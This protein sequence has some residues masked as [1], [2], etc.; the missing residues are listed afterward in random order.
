MAWVRAS[1]AE[2]LRRRS[3]SVWQKLL[4][5][6]TASS[7]SLASSASKAERG[8]LSSRQGAAAVTRA[9]DR[10]CTAHVAYQWLCG[11]V[12]MNYH[13]LADFRTAQGAFL[14]TLLTPSVATLMAA[15][16]VTLERVAQDGVRVRAS[17]GASSFLAGEAPANRLSAAKGSLLAVALSA[18][19]W[20]AIIGCVALL[21]H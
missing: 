5:T 2:V 14:D 6:L 10:L 18:G 16:A 1:S 21:R 11:G 8:S 7:T 19:L 12:P 20:A 15:G 13:T 9:L 17:A 3:L 4:Y